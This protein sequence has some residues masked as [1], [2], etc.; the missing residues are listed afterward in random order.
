MAGLAG[1]ISSNDDTEEESSS[2]QSSDQPDSNQGDSNP[3]KDESEDIDET[4]S[5]SVEWESVAGAKIGEGHHYPAPQL[6]DSTLVV[7]S[8][9]NDAGTIEGYNP[10]T[11]DHVWEVSTNTSMISDHPLSANDSVVVCQTDS[12]VKAISASGE[13]VWEDGISPYGDLLPVDDRIY[14]RYFP[15]GVRAGAKALVS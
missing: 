2:S 3:L 10:E 5:L 6:V 4:Q 9:L 8:G 12:G 13:V 15:T 14:I 1:C 7:V 11:G